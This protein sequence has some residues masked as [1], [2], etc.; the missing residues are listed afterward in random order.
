MAQV[1]ITSVFS[2]YRRK[3]YYPIECV[4]VYTFA[5]PCLGLLLDASLLNIS[6]RFI[7][8]RCIFFFASII[9]QWKTDKNCTNVICWSILSGYLSSIRFVLSR[10]MKSRCY[11]SS[12]TDSKSFVHYIC[13]II[14][15]P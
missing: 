15:V 10:Y 2:P 4:F 11:T 5:S 6:V 3:S 7:V 1:I 8:I 14:F 12:Y 9:I 13:G